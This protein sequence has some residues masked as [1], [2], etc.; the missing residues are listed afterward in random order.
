MSIMMGVKLL[1]K[2]V[3]KARRNLILYVV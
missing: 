1:C 3:D 2:T